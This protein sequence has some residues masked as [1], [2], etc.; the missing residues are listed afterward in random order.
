MPEDEHGHGESD[1]HTNLSAQVSEPESC[2]VGDDHPD[3]S[4]HPHQQKATSTKGS[5]L[6]SYRIPPR[7]LALSGGGVR[8]IAHVGAIRVFHE[9]GF[10]RCLDEVLGVSAGALF[11]LMLSLGYTIGEIEDLNLKFDFTLLRNPDPDFL[12]VFTET[13]GI[14]KGEALERLIISILRQKGFSPTATFADL[15]DRRPAFRCFATD[16]ATNQ[17]REFSIVVSPNISIVT[18]VRASM[19]LPLYYTPVTD[20]ETGNLLMDGGLL[21][22]L[23]HGHVLTLPD[24]WGLY[25]INPAKPS[26]EPTIFHQIYDSVIKLRYTRLL[27]EYDDFLI[28]IPCADTSPIHFDITLEERKTMI[29]TAAAAATAF[30]FRRNPVLHPKR[31]FSAS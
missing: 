20:P 23:P 9:H 12:F 30:L 26:V 27:R 28:R 25:F 15:R 4:P 10:L 7:R 17:S 29:A 16:I 14:D 24:S 5:R 2:P 3:L 13:L 19:S 8:A 21:H 1:A 31:R 11:A 6:V 22:N 18:A